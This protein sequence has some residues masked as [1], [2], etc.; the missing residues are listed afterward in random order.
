MKSI[1]ILTLLCAGVFVLSSCSDSF[2]DHAP[3][4]RTEINTEKKVVQL[5]TSAYP[6]SSYMFLSEL[7]SDNMIDNQAPH[8]PSSST[9]KQ[10]ESHYSNGPYSRWNDQIFKFEPATQATFNDW[11]S[12]GQLWSSYYSSIATVNHALEGIEKIVSAN[13]GKESNVIKAARAEALLIRAYSHFMLAQLFCQAYKDEELSKNDIGIPYV[14]EVEDVVRKDY[15]R[16]TVAETYAKIKADIEAAMPNVSDINYTK[17]KWHFNVNAAHAFAARFYLTVRDYQKVIEHANVVLGT[18]PAQTA[19][20]TMDYSRF[21]EDLS[22]LSD[23]AKVWQSPEI[24]NNLMLI[25]TNSIHNRL[26]FGYRYSCAGPSARAAFMIHGS[27]LWSGYILPAFAVAGFTAASSNSQDYGFTTSKIGEEFEYSDK[28]AG[29]GYPHV[30]I[31]PFTANVLLLERAEAKCM[32]KDYDGCAADLMAY[33]NNQRNSFNDDQKKS[34]VDNNYIREFTPDIF[35]SYYNVEQKDNANVLMD[36]SFTQANISP[37]FIIPQEAYKYM[38]CVQDMRRWET[39]LQGMRFFDL[40]RW[41]IEYSHIVGPE[42]TEYKL[43]GN[44][45]RRAVEVPWEAL[46]AGMESSRKTTPYNG[47]EAKLNKKELISK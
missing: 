22:S 18:D 46:S 45:P 21:T 28:I 2:L 20:M 33:W 6:T 11:D 3:D 4:E 10:R 16:G 5:L 25:A 15:P 42:K 37:S 44:D 12:P 43:T 30:I 7:L 31:M 14:T 13:G 40:K 23:Y 47:V 38:N 19:Q 26:V 9:K 39:V 1:K 36:W 41:G 17:P 27:P 32:L 35:D 34:Y 29:I 24:N 8:L